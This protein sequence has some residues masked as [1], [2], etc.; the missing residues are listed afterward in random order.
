M[1]GCV[2]AILQEW[3]NISSRV[4]TKVG[5]VCVLFTEIVSSQNRKVCGAVCVCVCA[6]SGV[7]VLDIVDDASGVPVRH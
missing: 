4:N 7:C 1:G 3:P 2:K 6:H 5:P